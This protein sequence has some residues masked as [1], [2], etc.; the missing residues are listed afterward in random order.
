[1]IDQNPIY[2]AL[3]IG[4]GLGGLVSAV[5][6]AKEGKRVC[7]I[8]KNNQFGGN[9]QTFSREK[10]IFDT[11][12]HYLGGLSKG[13]NLYRYFSYLGIISELDLEIMPEVFDK[14]YFEHTDTSYPIAQGYDAFIRHLCAYFPN[15]AEALEQYVKDLQS[16]CA[17]F[18]LYNLQVHEGYEK[19]VMQRGVKE[20][21][22]QL[23]NDPVLRAVLIGTNFLYAGSGEDTPFYVHALTVNSYLQSAY[24]CNKG[25]S[26]IAKLLIKELRKHGGHAVKREEVTAM[27]VNNGRVESIMTK[28]GNRYYA[29]MFI[30]NLDPRVSIAMAG[31]THFRSSFVK[32]IQNLEVTTS[33]FS[34]HV[35]LQPQTLKYIDYNLY[36]HS[37]TDSV[38]T[39]S[40][41]ES[42]D[43][44]AM[45]MVSMTE[46][47]SHQGYADTLTILTYMHF[48]EVKVWQHSHR[49]V[50]QQDDRG[51]GY[52]R[53]KQLKAQ[54][55]LDVV[56]GALPGLNDAVRNTY[57][58]T[59]LS[60]RDY[61]GMY[62][63][64]LYGHRKLADAPLKTYISPSTK[65]DNLFFTGHAI[66]MHGVLGVTIG[67]V[68]TCGEILG[69]SYLFEKIRR[70]TDV[71]I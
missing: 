36:G 35:V 41:Y 37:D 16:T 32:R 50:V 5:I 53:F 47:P 13:Q 25:G 66:A 70:E 14:I 57:V 9:L 39:A 58:S 38:W 69:K 6:L 62:Q 17:A 10:K 64:N 12:V 45:F 20:Y 52:K 30:S 23:T 24:R 42:K 15:Q 26:Q 18:P 34:L 59:P 61:I 71:T 3:V 29:D 4:S 11:G 48:D 28:Q 27:Q 43:W 51:S 21:F 19:Q 49:T 8:E 2:D 46:D 22:A 44:P 65:I 1:M 56:S 33:A 7:V 63:G 54:I 40:S 55:L 67:A 60:Y 31:E 68:A